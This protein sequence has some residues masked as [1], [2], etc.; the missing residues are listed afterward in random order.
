MT[1]LYVCAWA[2]AFAIA[3]VL[4]GS[5]DSFAALLVIVA[6]IALAWFISVLLSC[7]GVISIASIVSCCCRFT[8]VTVGTLGAASGVGGKGAACCR[9]CSC[10]CCVRASQKKFYRCQDDGTAS[11]AFVK[12]VH[13]HIAAARRANAAAEAGAPKAN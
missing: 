1:V 11:A 10:R 8:S 13:A 7:S 4:V 9:L 3:S 6:G 5:N 2:A 12:S